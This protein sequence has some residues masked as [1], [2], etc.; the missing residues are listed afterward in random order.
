MVLSPTR[1]TLP[2]LLIPGFMG[3][4]RFDQFSVHAEESGFPLAV[5][6]TDGVLPV[7]S[8]NGDKPGKAQRI[9][10]FCLSGPVREGKLP[11]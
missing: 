1:Y 6:D 3:D 5:K 9:R 11:C 4:V 10:G 2:P 7:E 8:G